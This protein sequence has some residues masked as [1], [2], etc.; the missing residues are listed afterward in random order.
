MT[1]WGQYLGPHPFATVILGDVRSGKTA[2]A[3]EIIEQ[4][5]GEAQ[6]YIVAPK[7]VHEKYPEWMKR[8]DPKNVVVPTDAILFGDD[9]HLLFHARDWARG[10]GR[11]LEMLARERHHYNTSLIVTSQDARVID[12]NLLPMLSALIIKKPALFQ[13]KYER[14]E[15]APIVRKADKL[16]PEPTGP[17]D[18]SYKKLAYVVS[19][20]ARVE[21]LVSD[22]GMAPWFN[23]DISKAWRGK[24]NLVK[25]QRLRTRNLNTVGKA[26]KMVGKVFG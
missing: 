3:S 10:G 9:L 6:P 17:E 23:D 24:G 20:H 18:D 4:Y 22:N 13:T 15:I 2:T 8:V 7:A 19:N 14:S 12:L 5:R 26:L 16:I 25:T 21:E 1:D 11:P